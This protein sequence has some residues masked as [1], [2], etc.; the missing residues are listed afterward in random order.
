MEPKV[1]DTYAGFRPTSF[2][3]HIELE[4]REFWC[5]MPVS[6]NRDSDCLTQSNFATFLEGLGGESET[7]EVHRFG[8]WGPGW[9]EII[10]VNPANRKAMDAAYDMARALENYP[11]LDDE[12]LSRREH[13]EAEEARDNWA[14]SDFRRDLIREIES[15]FAEDDGPVDEHQRWCRNTGMDM[16]V[17]PC[18]DCIQM[19][20]DEAEQFSA[21]A[22]DLSSEQLRTLAEKVCELEIERHN[23]GP[24]FSWKIDR[25]EVIEALSEMT[26]PAE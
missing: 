11:V 15:V 6:Q 8:H 4:D 18:G 10:L 26:V 21:K 14:A 5:V 17:C 1:F 22:D 24:H 12:D 16:M 3:R 7:V 2:D 20:H 9:F 19:I 25:D 13:E 23:D